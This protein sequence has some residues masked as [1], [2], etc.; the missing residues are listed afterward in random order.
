MLPGFLVRSLT[1]MLQVALHP[2][3]LSKGR[4]SSAC[5][6]VTDVGMGAGE[7]G[8]ARLL[9]IP[10]VAFEECLSA[11]LVLAESYALAGSDA[12]NQ[13]FY[14]HISNKSRH[15]LR[16]APDQRHRL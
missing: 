5:G 11:S 8:F 15:Q 4:I 3:L 16:R 14:F 1:E 9:N 12:S 7:G 10:N 13:A 2:A 6:N